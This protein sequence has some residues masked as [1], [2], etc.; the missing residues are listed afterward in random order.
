MRLKHL[1]KNKRFLR[2]KFKYSRIQQ[3]AAMKKLMFFSTIVL[4]LFVF[5][6]S[7]GNQNPDTPNIGAAEMSQALCEQYGGSW[8]ECGSPCL[9]TESDVCVALCQQ[10]CE[11]S[12]I[13]GFACPPGYECRLAG[14]IADEMG[15]CFVPGQ[16][17]SPE[18]PNK[19][20]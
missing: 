15:V 7:N 13:A 9:G 18:A 19:G 1:S 4:V 3:I 17:T 20:F 6:C 5:G 2:Q 8:N 10:Q 16:E 12:G 14:G 11:C